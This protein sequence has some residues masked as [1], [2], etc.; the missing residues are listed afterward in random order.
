MNHVFQD[1]LMK[2]KLVFSND[3]LIYSSTIDE[4]CSHLRRVL[5]LLREHQ[6]FAKDLNVPSCR[7][8]SSI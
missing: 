4:R 8:K 5:E 1:Q 6:L 7:Q 2:S 3:I